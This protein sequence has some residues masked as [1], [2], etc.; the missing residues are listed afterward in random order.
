MICLLALI[1]CSICG[2]F[3]AAYR[4]I[5]FEAFDCVFRKATLR[6][7]NTGLNTRL[8]GEIVGKLF[9]ISPNVGKHVFKFFEWYSWFF[10]IIT[11]V[12]LIY[13]GI[14][15]YNYIWYG[16]CNGAS[17]A[18]CVFNAA[19][20]G[21]LSTVG[22]SRCGVAAD[23]QS[24]LIAPDINTLDIPWS[25]NATDTF[26]EFGCYS[27]KYT[28]DAELVVA[29]IRGDKKTRFGFI[30]Y[31]ILTHPGSYESAIA[32]ACANKQGKF[33]A[34][35]DG[36]FML[37][38]LSR[39]NFID[40][41]SNLSFDLNTFTTCIDTNQTKDIVDKQIA[42]GQDAGIYGTPTF[43][44]GNVSLVGPQTYWRLSHYVHR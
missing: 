12:S 24:E 36:L 27:C 4:K 15:A 1:V 9:K 19:E 8:K 7:C 42:Y 34:Y 28:K 25:S 14:G 18:F 3:S 23:L 20:T 41:A 29:Q 21:E 31:P 17:N 43:F 39:N 6:P 26:I 16:N 40:L 37:S 2:I 10:I 13:T 5:A 22:F 38:N 33:W 30:A 44:I 11:I 32:A 35:H